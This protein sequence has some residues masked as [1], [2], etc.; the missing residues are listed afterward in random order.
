MN[1]DPNSVS[2]AGQFLIPAVMGL[3]VVQVVVAGIGAY[4]NK[5]KSKE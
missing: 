1:L 2:T 4:L 5:V 3:P